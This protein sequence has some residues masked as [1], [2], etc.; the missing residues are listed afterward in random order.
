MR[1]PLPLLSCLA[2]LLS[3][4]LAAR[5]QPVPAAQPVSLGLASEAA[6]KAS[7]GFVDLPATECRPVYAPGIQEVGP[8]VAEAEQQTRGLVVV[9]QTCDVRR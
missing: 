6:E 3:A 7:I 8:A 2:L 1:N 5:A 9:G 4:G